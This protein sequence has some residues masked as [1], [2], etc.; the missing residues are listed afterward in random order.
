MSLHE[1]SVTSGIS[2]HRRAEEALCRQTMLLDLTSDLIR[3]SEP[4]ELGRMTFERVSSAFGADICFN[5]RLDP[6]GKRLRLVFGRGIPPEQ[7]E[8]AQSLELGQAFCG[9]AAGGCE[10][11]VADMQRIACDPKGAF[12]RDLG[13]TAYACHPLMAA[14]GR[15]LGTFSVASTTREGFTDEEVAWL[16]R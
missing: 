13:A 11:V 9:T 3:A 1:E 12:V 16:A 14:D 4:G 7:L 2:E 15:P 10:A 6:A 8:A 5:Y